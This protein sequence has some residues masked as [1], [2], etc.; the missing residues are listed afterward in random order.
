MQ[1]WISELGGYAP[2]VIS[3]GK[4]V[5]VL[6]VGWIVA[7]A[8]SRFVRSRVT[9]NPRIDETIGQFAASMV[10]Y[11][12]L[13]IVL[14]AVLNLFGIRATSLVAVL[15]AATLAIGLALQGTLADLAAGFMLI[16]FR[17]YRLGQYVDIGGTSG[18]VKEINLFFTELNTPQNV[19]I[20]VPNGQAWG[21]IITNYSAHDTRRCDLTLGIDYDDDAGKAMKIITDLADGDG[22]VHDDPA[23][24]V[25]VTNLGDS[26]VDLTARL[27]WNAADYWELKFAMT[28][29]VKEAFDKKGISIPYPHSVEIQ[30]KG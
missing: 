26:S 12:I 5:I 2:L 24:W 19:Q 21:S 22:R 16:L 11:L 15:G 30:K 17:P 18:T 4:A 10:Y 20:I 29:A 7:G 1:E 27:W 28:R 13:I 8:I 23:P 25:R 9:A 3:A 14:V 6:V